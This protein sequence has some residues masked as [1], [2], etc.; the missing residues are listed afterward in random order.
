MD[1]SDGIASLLYLMIIT[2]LDCYSTA[3]GTL[4]TKVTWSR[5]TCDVI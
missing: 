5:D 1:L 2:L 4:K 3:I